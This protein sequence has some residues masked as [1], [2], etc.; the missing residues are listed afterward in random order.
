MIRTHRLG[1]P[2]A[3]ALQTCSKP[4]SCRSSTWEEQANHIISQKR[5]GGGQNAIIPFKGIPQGREDLPHPFP[6]QGPTTSWRKYSRNQVF[7]KGTCDNNEMGRQWLPMAADVCIRILHQTVTTSETSET[8]PAGFPIHMYI[9][10]GSMPYETRLASP[11]RCLPPSSAPSPKDS[12]GAASRA[13]HLVLFH[14][15][16]ANIHTNVIANVE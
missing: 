2:L 7:S 15:D 12:N 11:E 9:Y 16:I 4:A 1:V 13:S 14:D 5:A 6:L 3:P 8:S 10:N